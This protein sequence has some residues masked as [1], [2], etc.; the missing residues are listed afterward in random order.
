MNQLYL[1]DLCNTQFYNKTTS[2]LYFRGTFDWYHYDHLLL[3]TEKGFCCIV[4][5]PVFINNFHT[6]GT[7]TIKDKNEAHNLHVAIPHGCHGT[8]LQQL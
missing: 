6:L 3:N 1:S 2:N 4:F 5:E 7:L 8:R